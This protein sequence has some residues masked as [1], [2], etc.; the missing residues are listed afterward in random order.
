[1]SNNV[2]KSGVQLAL[3]SG[4]LVT[5]DISHNNIEDL[6]ELMALNAT[7]LEQLKVSYNRIMHLD[8]NFFSH[9]TKLRRLDLSYNSL[10]TVD[11]T[12]LNI[13]P[14][15]LKQINIAGNPFY[16]TCDTAEF[17]RWVTEHKHLLEDTMKTQC[18]HFNP[19]IRKP[20]TTIDQDSAGTCD[21]PAS[22]AK[23]IAPLVVLVIL[24]T[25]MLM[26]VI[27]AACISLRCANTKQM[28]D[29]QSQRTS[30]GKVTISVTGIDGTGKATNDNDD[31]SAG[32]T[33][34]SLLRCIPMKL[35]SSKSHDNENANMESPLMEHMHETEA[36]I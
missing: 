5:L 10:V 4:T 16:C 18:V 17:T 20:I 8:T 23:Y 33:A 28:K 36:N 34:S 31:R 9:F 35:F 19:W 1:M 14:S 11:V 22:T 24:L 25:L 6:E 27:T 3:T 30:C 12:V 7:S 13:V 21:A 15:S 26:C 29:K 32:A 2:V